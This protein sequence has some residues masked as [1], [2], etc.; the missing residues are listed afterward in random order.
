[1]ARAGRLQQSEAFRSRWPAARL[2]EE[3][4]EPSL[5]Q[6]LSRPS[7]WGQLG[8]S[9]SFRDQ[10]H[11]SCQQR[12]SMVSGGKLAH[13]A[14]LFRAL[15]SLLQGAFPDCS[16]LRLLPQSWGAVPHSDMGC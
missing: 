14:E 1:M 2:R 12:V 5:P 9:S 3:S 7:L 6:A 16:S 11:S 15:S 13:L 8:A 10:A 4:E